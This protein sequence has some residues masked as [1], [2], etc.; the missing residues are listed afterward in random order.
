MKKNPTSLLNPPKFKI[1]KP[2]KKRWSV[3]HPSWT[4][5]PTGTHGLGSVPCLSHRFPVYSQATFFICPMTDFLICAVEII[6]L[7]F[8]VR[9]KP[10]DVAERRGC[11]DEKS[12]PGDQS[13]RGV[14]PQRIVIHAARISVLKN[15][16]NYF[17]ISNGLIFFF[18]SLSGIFFVEFGCP[19]AAADIWNIPC[20]SPFSSQSVCLWLWITPVCSIRA[21]GTTQ[22]DQKNNF[23][24]LPTYVEIS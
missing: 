10:T 5:H 7:T 6:Y 3:S 16:G 17:Q 9:I 12:H 14:S 8:I 13:K 15:T 23:C 22:W 21:P 4:G 11:W 19:G 24:H 1:S 2:L 18:P 20:L